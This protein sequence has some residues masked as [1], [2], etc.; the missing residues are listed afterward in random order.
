MLV[1]IVERWVK[2]FGM[3]ESGS[4]NLILKMYIILFLVFFILYRFFICVVMIFF[5]FVVFYDG[6]FVIIVF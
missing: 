1:I 4:E 3:F 6:E 5:F 2:I